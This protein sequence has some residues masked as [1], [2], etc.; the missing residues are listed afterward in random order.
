MRF[1][2]LLLQPHFLLT[3]PSPEPPPLP[4]P[5]SL[6]HH[7]YTQTV[8]MWA[9]RFCP[10]LLGARPITPVRLLLFFATAV[11]VDNLYVLRQDS[12][13]SRCMAATNTTP[14]TFTPQVL[15]CDPA[16]DGQKF[17]INRTTGG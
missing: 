12:D 6:A 8:Q 3:A 14:T 11:G 16:S 5:T 4:L 7:H 15:P 9:E 13:T 10:P 2:S 17:F 1:L